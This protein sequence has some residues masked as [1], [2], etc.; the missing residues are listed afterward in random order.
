MRIYFHNKK[1]YIDN[2]IFDV[3]NEFFEIEQGHLLFS[4]ISLVKNKNTSHSFVAEELEVLL[5]EMFTQ[6]IILGEMFLNDLELIYDEEDYNKNLKKGFF[7][8]CIKNLKKHDKSFNKIQ[9]KIAWLKD[10]EE[11][12]VK[13]RFFLRMYLDLIFIYDEVINYTINIKYNKKSIINLKSYNN[14]YKYKMYCK[15]HIYRTLEEEIKECINKYNKKNFSNYLQDSNDYFLLGFLLD[16]KFQKDLYANVNSCNTV[17]LLLDRYLQTGELDKSKFNKFIDESIFEFKDENINIINIFYTNCL[18]KALNIEYMYLLEN[19]IKS[20][21]CKNCKKY[22]IPYTVKAD[23]C[24]EIYKDTG[25]S[26]SEIGGMLARQKK[27]NEDL[28]LKTYRKNHSKRLMRIKRNNNSYTREMLDAWV[29]YAKELMELTRIGK[30]TP[31]EF[32]N[33]IDR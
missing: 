31:E 11:N 6:S 13:L 16:D 33:L 4:L 23:F 24:N 7:H 27:I 20:K 12:Q 29:K 3:A 25:K 22:F 5:I 14:I 19:N 1:E 2:K 32:E 17:N 8:N 26:C 15:E 10:T 28:I 30:L 18:V 21:K 9:T